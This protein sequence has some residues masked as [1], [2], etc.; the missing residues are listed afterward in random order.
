MS[1]LSK[2]TKNLTAT[3]VNPVGVIGT[4][5][6]RDAAGKLLPGQKPPQ[7]QQGDFNGLIR[8][9]ND[10][11][12]GEQAKVMAE[13][14]K[15]KELGTGYNTGY[16]AT[17]EQNIKE[18]ADLL[19]SSQQRQLMDRVPE[20]AEQANLSGV[21]RSTGMGNAVA[22]EAG[23]LAAATSEQLGQY[24]LQQKNANLADTMGTN[25][26]YLKGR[27]SSLERGTGLTDLALQ[28]Q[29]AKETG[30]A[31]A[32]PVKS[33]KGAGALTGALGGAG[34]GAT[35]GGPMG[36]AIGGGLGLIGGGQLGG[37]S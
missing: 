18:M 2:A 33:G 11:A 13:V 24:G 3:V 29:I 27:Y 22:R 21:F 9:I 36:A 37:K 35:V 4:G 6:L 20:L 12:P 30:Q 19:A 23:N 28:A 32:A 1:W 31:L 34:V 7:A 5:L 15:Q 14:D 25:A 8:Q 10:M 26:D 16:A 17:R